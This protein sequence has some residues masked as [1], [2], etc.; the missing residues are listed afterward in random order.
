M[1]CG[2]RLGGYDK[3][4]TL[5]SGDTRRFP[6]RASLLRIHGRA[7]DDLSPRS[8]TAFTKLPS[9]LHWSASMQSR[10]NFAAE[11]DL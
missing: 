2:Q 10:G 3:T 5:F 8:T 6:Q 4:R 7:C 11:G 1:V 9:L